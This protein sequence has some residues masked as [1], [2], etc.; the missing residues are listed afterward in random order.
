MAEQ[1]S[2]FTGCQHTGNPVLDSLVN[3]YIGAHAFPPSGASGLEYM[4]QVHA[5]LLE[6][7][8]K[9][10]KRRTSDGRPTAGELA[11]PRKSLSGLAA[12]AA[13]K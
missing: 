13:G 11:N 8:D 7:Y 10:P 12:E 9:E 4:E 6:L 3:L 5:K 1:Q 2:S